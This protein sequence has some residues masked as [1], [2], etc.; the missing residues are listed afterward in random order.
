[1]SPCLNY[2]TGKSSTPST[3]CCSSLDNV[4]K[5]KPVC[6]CEVINGGD[7]GLGISINQTL[8]LAL[9]DACKIQTPPLS[10]CHDHSPAA[11]PGISP[12]GMPP[13]SSLGSPVSSSVQDGTRSKSAT[14]TNG[15][16][17]KMSLT[18]HLAVIVGLIIAACFA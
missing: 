3:S 8:A 18:G 9:P 5:T 11:S 17:M 14:S 2:I 4:L 1:M 15:C 13:E 10:K 7:S 16:S 12:A 6:L